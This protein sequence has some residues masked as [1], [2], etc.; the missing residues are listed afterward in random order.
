M[1]RAS[2][3]KRIFYFQLTDD[4]MK[5]T[6]RMGVTGFSTTTAFHHP[7]QKGGQDRT[8]VQR[9]QIVGHSI[10][11]TSFIQVR[12]WHWSSNPN[13]IIRHRHLVNALMAW[14][15]IQ[16]WKYKRTPSPIDWLPALP[17]QRR[18]LRQLIK[19]DMLDGTLDKNHGADIMTSFIFVVCSFIIIKTYRLSCK[20]W[21]ST[22]KPPE[23]SNALTWGS[24]L[25]RRS[26]V[27]CDRPC[28]LDTLT[29]TSL[30]KWVW[31][32]IIFNHFNYSKTV[33]LTSRRHWS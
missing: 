3:C 20:W 23:W 6:V 10:S 15:F 29:L 22:S 18:R 26:L 33:R 17:P 5:A 8:A 14:H 2:I 12:S 27:E 7:T 19:S 4:L 16:N 11:F 1:C 9:R 25:S 21:C 31:K 13:K 30:F 24:H 28:A 32:W